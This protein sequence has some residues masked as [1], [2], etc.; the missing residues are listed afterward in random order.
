MKDYKEEI[1][2]VAILDRQYPQVN[3]TKTIP[4]YATKKQN[5]KNSAVVATPTFK[6][7]FFTLVSES[8]VGLQQ[9]GQL[10]NME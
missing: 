6:P 9:S 5:S 4:K 3:I 1:K 7:I 2:I 8:I 10:K